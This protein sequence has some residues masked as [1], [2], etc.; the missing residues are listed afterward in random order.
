MESYT[1][2]SGADIFM[3]SELLDAKIRKGIV[4]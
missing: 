4:K 3:D 1:C 2:I